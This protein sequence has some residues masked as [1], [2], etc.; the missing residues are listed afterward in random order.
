MKIVFLQ[1][2]DRESVLAD[3]SLGH[4]IL[5]ESWGL[6]G[7]VERRAMAG[8][9]KKLLI[10]HGNVDGPFIFTSQI[11]HASATAAAAYFAAQAERIFTQ[12]TVE[13][14]DELDQPIAI[15]P[16]AIL[17]GIQRTLWRGA[18]LQL[19]YTFAINTVRTTSNELT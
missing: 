2:E 16:D 5:I 11:A 9:A 18:A 12:D 14:R 4:G 3:N 10:A 15:M 8:A 19:R 17:E 7:V 13:I 6:A 1:G